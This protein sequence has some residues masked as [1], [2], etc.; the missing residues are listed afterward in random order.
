MKLL[1]SIF[2]SLVLLSSCSENNADFIIKNAHVYTINEQFDT[3]NV[4]VIKDGKFLAIGD[5]SLLKQYHA[6][7]IINANGNY[8]YPGFI[9]AHCHFTGYAMD[10]YKLALFGTKSFSDV[11]SKVKEYAQFNKREWI[12][13][14]GWDQNDWATKEYPTKDSLDILFPTTPVF[15]MRIDGHAILCNQA[16]LDKAGININ[17][18]VDG[19]EVLQ[20][21]GKLTGI[22]TDKAIDIVKAKIPARTQEEVTKDFVITQD[23]CFGLGLT[24]LVDCG[25]KK[26]V[27]QWLINAAEKNKIQ[28]NVAVM[29]SDEPENY[30]EYFGKTPY[31][32]HG[33][34]IIGFKVYADGSLGSR[35]AYMI[36]EYSDRHNHHGFMLKN[37]D[38]LNAL[39]QKMI[40]SPFQLCTH[41]I[42][43]AANREVLKAY[44]KVL[45]TKNDR[46]WRIEHVQVITPED[47][48]YFGDY[49][50]IP[51]VQPTHA[52]S[53]MYWASDRIGNERIK[54]AYAYN[55]LLK[56]NNW[57]P[58]GTDFP[59]ESLNPMYTFYAAVFR[60][61][62]NNKPKDGF[63]VE[64]ALS[65]ENA[66]RGMTIWAAKS[67][68][69][70]KEKGSIE[71]GKQAD[72]V[73]MK[74]D[75][76]HAIADSIYNSK[77]S[78]TF[79]NGKRVFDMQ[80]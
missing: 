54:S 14:S 1:I 23:E 71:V 59:V 31:R 33:I 12:E 57:L 22:L 26:Q 32:A 17:T 37:I 38:S 73:I 34:H 72:F 35:G 53:D 15:L 40:Q 75:L 56:Q 42:G 63:Q 43:D 39:A 30:E 79:V 28:I 18:I 27:A 52:T 80:K 24:S 60:I 19:G 45:Q 16:A 6:V 7:N 4:L 46:R 74:T 20:E 44:A 8:I 9:D 50:I 76:M 11:L 5:E 48:H 61:D 3:A 65:R 55:D 62:K 66:L 70:D 36:N 64:N 51:S 41:A 67:V 13:G 69:E 2:F 77:I 25:I 29:L 21:N 49:S 10:K 47:F 58:L 78:S 68:F